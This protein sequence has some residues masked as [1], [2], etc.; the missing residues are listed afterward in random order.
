[1]K[2]SSLAWVSLGSLG[3]SV[4]LSS[5][6]AF[7]FVVFVISVAGGVAATWLA[8]RVIVRHL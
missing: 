4:P 1:M 5:V 2:S 7:A 8:I 3:L 6:A